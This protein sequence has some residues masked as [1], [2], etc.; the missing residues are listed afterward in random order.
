[1]KMIDHFK[2]AIRFWLLILGIF[3]LPIF[4]SGEVTGY[5]G[6]YNYN[7]GSYSGITNGVINQSFTAVEYAADTVAGASAFLN[8]N[9][10]LGAWRANDHAF[11][12]ASGGLGVQGSGS[13]LW[14]SGVSLHSTGGRSPDPWVGFKL[15]RFYVDQIY[16]GV[17]GMYS[18]L[19]G[20]PIYGSYNNPASSDNWAGIV[21]AQSR[22][23]AYVTDRYAISL[24]PSVYWLPLTNEVGWG[25][26]SVFTG[27]GAVTVPNALVE[28][29]L[30]FPL[31]GTFSV[32]FYDQFRALYPQISV[33][34]NS[35]AYWA[36]L[37]DSTPVDF[38]GRYQFG[39]FG[40][41][42]QIDSTRGKGRFALNDSLYG[43]EYMT[44]MN[45]A[46]LR[47]NGQHSGNT[48]SNIYYDRTDYWNNNLG[49][50]SGWNT[51]GALVIQKG[52]VI[53]PYAR[54]EI[55][56][57]DILETHYQQAVIGANAL[58][59][60]GLMA[61]AEAGW[62]GSKQQY[63]GTSD[64]WIARTGFRQRLGQYTFH[65]VD[66]GRTPVENYRNRYLSNFAQ[67]YITQ[68]FGP[69]S[70]V[71]FYVEQADMDV[72]GGTS[73]IERSSTSTG[74]MATTQF[75]DVSSLILNASYENVDV[76]SINR[77]W[78]LW[79]YRLMYRRKFGSSLNGIAYYQYQ[80]SGSGVSAQDKF[81]EQL[82]F[83][84]M[85]KQF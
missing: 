83:I 48:F 37:G 68:K 71:T 7:N 70:D 39:G 80:E 76:P 65:G 44:F 24:N 42:H 55:V 64:T 50:R 1:M 15:G 69:R 25:V 20:Q 40:G 67:Y 8:Q 28:M 38:A 81:S 45:Q 17:G 85:M 31:A 9:M 21:W 56:A 11:A 47:L 10:N 18:D 3:T 33:M 16:G 82:L 14:S 5:N 6:D 36:S 2:G 29:A 66:I 74:M 79:T 78:E 51:L 34:R 41:G 32:T 53:S 12:V 43:T 57:S 49:E 54:Y 73:A 61:Y 62:M 58:Y 22:F 63:Q 13:N 59:G 84:G 23:T 35:P 72:L 77:G 4:K 52:P 30:R 75:S 19:Q 46:S 26:G 60:P 27:I